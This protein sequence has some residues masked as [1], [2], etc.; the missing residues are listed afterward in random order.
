MYFSNL[1]DPN[2]LA[3]LLASAT[4]EQRLLQKARE[5]DDQTL[6]IEIAMI[7]QREKWTE[8]RERVLRMS[9]QELTQELKSLTADLEP[10]VEEYRSDLD[11]DSKKLQTFLKKLRH[12][13]ARKDVI[14]EEQA[15]RNAEK[16]FTKRVQRLSD[17]ELSEEMK[18]LVKQLKKL[19]QDFDEG[20]NTEEL[21]RRSKTIDRQLAVVKEEQVKRA[22]VHSFAKNK[23]KKVTLFNYNME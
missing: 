7:R 5:W 15:F 9:D 3:E 11:R 13:K 12:T 17:V 8:W 1:D 6:A 22:E 16:V 4:P 2:A 21:R 20:S 10:H 14:R 18:A 19:S 23:N